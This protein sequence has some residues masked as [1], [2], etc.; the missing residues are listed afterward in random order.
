[1]CLFA[2]DEYR[3]WANRLAHPLLRPL[4]RQAFALLSRE[5]SRISRWLSLASDIEIAESLRQVNAPACAP[6]PRA[7]HVERT[8]SAPTIPVETASTPDSLANHEATH[9]EAP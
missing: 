7:E 3:D 8:T 9:S 1:M 5:R 6:R 4:A 2:L